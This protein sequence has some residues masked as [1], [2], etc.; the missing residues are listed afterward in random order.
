M[1]NRMQTSGA[2]EAELSE[3]IAV[4]NAFA[5]RELLPHALELDLGDAKTLAACWRGVC[6][7]G[8]HRGLLPESAG[9]VGLSLGGLLAVLEELAV[10]DGG[11]AAL[12]LLSNGALALLPE[13]MLSAI[14]EAARFVLVPLPEPG[15]P[16]STALTI[17]GST[18]SGRISFALGGIGADGLVLVG[19]EGEEDVVVAIEAGSRGLRIERDEAQ[20]A[21]HGAPAA[22][23]ECA[24]APVERLGGGELALSARILLNAGIAAIAR[25]IARRSRDAA[26]EYA[27]NRFQGGSMII[28]Y[29]AIRDMIARMSERN[30]VTGGA[31]AFAGYSLNGRGPRS[32]RE[33]LAQAIA[34]K[35]AATDAA[36][37]STTDAVQVFGGVGY[38]HETGVE[39]LMRDARY[40]QLFPQA[41][42]LARD[43]LVELERG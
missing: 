39:K 38:M 9:G 3:I 1:S 10:G 34:A 29:G 31:A 30:R 7:I 25:G 22:I 6:E 11:I 20:L 43:Q 2:L 8:L 24:K 42:W 33:A 36:V 12:T 18:A 23:I 27:E 40:C 14:D 21:L 32:G 16:G 15:T 28:E 17:G 4:T 26:L 5:T 37:E 13:A 19:R 41:N 35:T